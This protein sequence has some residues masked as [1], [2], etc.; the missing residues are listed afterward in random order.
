MIVQN[1][2]SKKTIICVVL[3]LSSF[4]ILV[5]LNTSHVKY[6][7]LD[8]GTQCSWDT[9]WRPYTEVVEYYTS[10]DPYH[11][12]DEYRRSSVHI[13]SGALIWRDSNNTFPLPSLKPKTYITYRLDAGLSFLNNTSSAIDKGFFTI[14]FI[15]R[16]ST[17]AKILLVI[18][19]TLF[20][21]GRRTHVIRRS[22]VYLK[23]ANRLVLREDGKAV[24]IT[25]FFINT[26]GLRRG[27]RFLLF[28]WGRYKYFGVVKKY[29]AYPTLKYGR[30]DSLIVYA[31]KS[32]PTLVY[33]TDTGVLLDAFLMKYDGLLLVFDIM[34][35]TVVKLYETNLD[36]GPRNVVAELSAFLIHP[37]TI[38]I[39]LAITIAIIYM[40]IRSTR[41]RRYSP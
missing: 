21:M 2:K 11:Y 6:S 25:Y 22:I 40:L 29:V 12:E 15:T 23:T 4:A 20:G 35:V 30:Q 10:D 41:A 18:N 37:Y 5:T 32:I 1:N 19:L 9:G 38:S 31:N 14:K 28:T 24:G 3:L 34:E 7:G 33:D 8:S 39:I 26:S 17:H 36:L 27:S 16:N 13:D